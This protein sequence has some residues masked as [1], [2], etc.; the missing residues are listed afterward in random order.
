MKDMKFSNIQKESEKIKIKK[1]IN[2]YE[3]LKAQALLK[4]GIMTYDKI[5]KG[6]IIDEEFTLLCDE[7]KGFDI[8]IYTKYMQL[9]SFENKSNKI[10]CQCGYVAFKNEKFCPQCGKSL[11]EEEESYII[12]K[13]CN[14]ETEKDSNFCACCGS[15]IKEEP[16][17]YDDEVYFVNEEVKIKDTIIEEVPEVSMIEEDFGKNF[18][19]EKEEIALEEDNFENEIVEHNNIIETDCIEIEGREFL[20]DHQD[21]RPE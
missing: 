8:E 1:N 10:V 14:Q 3:D 4:L 13:H 9:R 16:I 15:K 18:L 2:D 12:C 5:R 19:K 6:E 17:H 20:K 11:I 7:I 21:N